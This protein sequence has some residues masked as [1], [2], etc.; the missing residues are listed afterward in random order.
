MLKTELAVLPL[1][2]A[3]VNTPD[4]TE[5]DAAPDEL[6]VGVNVAVYD[7]PDPL[8]DDNKPPETVTSPTTK[9][10]DDSDKVNVNDAVCPT[11]KVPLP[12]LETETVGAVWSV[13]ETVYVPVVTI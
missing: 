2:A 12:D 7:T 13:T 4:P 1:P 11:S 10:V 6:E 8:N 9:F 3:S 5:T